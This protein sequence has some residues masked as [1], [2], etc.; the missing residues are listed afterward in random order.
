MADSL[1]IENRKSR[2]SLT[3]FDEIL[4]GG[5]HWPVWTLTAVQKFTKKS[6]VADGRH[7]E[8]R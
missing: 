7:F 5:V 3:D 6:K 2:N 4:Y 8:N 1:H